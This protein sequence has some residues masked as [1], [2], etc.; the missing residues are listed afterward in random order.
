[1]T[2]ETFTKKMRSATREMHAISDSLVNAKLTFAFSNKSVWGEGLLVFYEIFRYLEEAMIRLKDTP[3]GEL[4]IEGLQR[5][6]AFEKD[7]SFYLGSDWKKTYEPRESV[8]KYLLHLRKLE[9]S[10]ANQLMVYIYHLYMGL[11][12]GGQILRGKRAIFNQFMLIPHQYAYQ[13]AVTDFGAT[14]ISKMKKDLVD[15]MNGIAAVLDEKTKEKLIEESKTVFVMNNEILRSIQGANAVI[16][17]KFITVI[18]IILLT[19]IVY[20]TYYGV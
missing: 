7:L 17:K 5:T 4:C 20:I 15:A 1:M 8:I 12:S 19:G 3:V 16:L 10:D 2:E 14:T 18:I 6:E 13:D 11:L 9:E